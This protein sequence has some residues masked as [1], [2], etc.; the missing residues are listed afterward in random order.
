[1]SLNIVRE[2]NVDFHDSKYIQVNAKQY[3]LASR[4]IL[5]SCYNQG[6]FFPIHAF[7]HSAFVKYKK[8][9]GNDV[10]NTC[11]IN[12]EGKVLIELTEQMLAAIGTCYAELMILNNNP[13]ET[14]TRPVVNNTGDLVIN[15]D[16]I[17]STMNFCIN[18]IANTVDHE[19]IE[20]TSEYNALNELL[21]KA[22]EDYKYIVSAAKASEDSAKS[23]ASVAKTSATNAEN[24]AT[25]ALQSELAAATSA[26][27]AAASE[28][29]AS[30][31]EVSAGSSRDAAKASET[32]AKASENTAIEHAQ[33]SK[34]YA[35]GGTGTRP[36]EDIDNSKYYYEYTKLVCE[37]LNGSFTPMGTIGFAELATVSKGTGYV[38]YINES[39]VTDDTFRGGAG[40]SYP[41]GT[42]VYYTA[43]GYWDCMISRV[44][45]VTHDGNGN[46][47]L[48]I[49]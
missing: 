22:T 3:D 34:S 19:D 1:M 18:V 37:S 28:G 38:Y 36:N 42:T 39:F 15:T 27:N 41:A 5:V 6:E 26:T 48:N 35:V 29:K 32:A 11:Q 17:L 24:S 21:V 49:T 47:T 33:I 23:S 14:E 44:A 40:V 13:V 43:D 10:F 8:S 25:A 9:D 2:I 12:Y 30:V 20:S 31:H 7:N 45:T 46:V 16:N 4:F